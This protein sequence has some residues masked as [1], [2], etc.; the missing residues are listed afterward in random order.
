V[1][2]GLGEKN[3]RLP[4]CEARSAEHPADGN[5]RR[6]LPGAERQAMGKLTCRHGASPKAAAEWRSSG[7]FC[8]KLFNAYIR[9]L[10]FLF[11]FFLLLHLSFLQNVDKGTQ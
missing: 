9:L 6:L 4:D 5:T 1:V 2:W 10:V 8:Y 11:Q 3:P 7:P